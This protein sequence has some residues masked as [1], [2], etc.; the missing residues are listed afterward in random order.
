MCIYIYIHT[1]TC[2]CSCVYIYVCYPVSMGLCM[3]LHYCSFQMHVC[4][5]YTRMCACTHARTYSNISVRILCPCTHMYIHVGRKIAQV[6]M[7]V[8]IYIYIYILSG[9]HNWYCYTA[10]QSAPS[11]WTSRH[12]NVLWR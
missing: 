5:S 11:R 4:K 7:C 3:R 10:K 6:C 9:R 8:Y 1:H 2:I 12:G